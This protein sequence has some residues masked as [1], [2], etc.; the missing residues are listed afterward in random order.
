MAP[1]YPNHLRNMCSYSRDTT[2]ASNSVVHMQNSFNDKL[3]LDVLKN[4]LNGSPD[5]KNFAHYFFDKYNLYSNPR[6]IAT[7]VCAGEGVH[8][9]V[10]GDFMVGMLAVY[11]SF[12]SRPSMDAMG[13]L[14]ELTFSCWV[15]EGV[16]A[17]ND[18]LAVC[19][20]VVK[21]ALK[22]ERLPSRYWYE[23]SMKTLRETIVTRPELPQ[24]AGAEGIALFEKS[25]RRVDALLKAAVHKRPLPQDLFSTPTGSVE[26]YIFGAFAINFPM[27]SLIYRQGIQFLEQFDPEIAQLLAHRPRSSD[28]DWTPGLPGGARLL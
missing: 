8:E 25:R 19:Y 4:L 14:Q 2:L 28:W 27:D 11:S 7:C 20:H 23:D 5:D 12:I 10:R 18:Q 24:D 16:S 3:D 6:V 17:S 21:E 13:S 1:R 22:S 26:D 9:V 15:P